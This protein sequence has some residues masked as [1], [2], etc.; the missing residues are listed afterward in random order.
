MKIPVGH[1]NW[2]MIKGLLSEN[3]QHD[4]KGVIGTYAS[5]FVV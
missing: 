3:E 5:M 4:T 2:W 1:D